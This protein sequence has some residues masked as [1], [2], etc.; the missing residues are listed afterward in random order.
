MA[1]SPQRR[2]ASR[3]HEPASPRAFSPTLPVTQR[4]AIYRCCP[5][6]TASPSGVRA[7]ALPPAPGDGDGAGECLGPSRLILP[8]LTR[9]LCG[10]RRAA[11]GPSDTPLT[12]RPQPETV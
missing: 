10:Y 2:I 1:Q 4:V 7:W 9:A 12:G 5:L 11:E 6:P 8:G 3:C